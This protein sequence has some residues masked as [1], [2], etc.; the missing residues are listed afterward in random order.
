MTA[1]AV[2][3]AVVVEHPPIYWETILQ[4]W[5]RKEGR[6]YGAIEP[7]KWTKPSVELTPETS[8]GFDVIEF[9]ETVCGI[10]LYPWQRWL[11]IHALELNPDGTY[12]FKRVHLLVG[13]QNGK[14]TLA[15]LLILYWLF[16]DASA[17]PDKLHPRD[18]SILA[19]AQN[20]EKAAETWEEVLDYCD[21]APP[22]DKDAATMPLVPALQKLSR[23][24]SRKT[25]APLVRTRVGSNYGIASIAGTKSG[26]G[27]SKARIFLDE[28]REHRSWDAWNAIKNTKNARWNAQLWT[29]SNAGDRRAVVLKELRAQ[30]LE[31]IDEYEKYV[32][33][34]LWD[35]ERWANKHDATTGLFEWSAEPGIPQSDVAGILQSNPSVG[36][37]NVDLDTLVADSKSDPEAEFRTEVLCQWVESLVTPHIDPT[38]WDACHSKTAYPTG[39]LVAGF[40]VSF[41]RKRAHVAIAGIGAD[42]IPVVELATRRTGSAWILNYAEKLRENWGVNEIAI[43]SRGC[44][45]SEWV[46]PLRAAGFHVHEIQGF[47]VGASCGLFKE[48]VESTGVRHRDQN[49]LTLSVSGTQAK[50]NG[51]QMF[52]DRA[53]SIVD[54]SATVAVSEAV[55][56]LLRL[57]EPPPPAESVYESRGIRVLRG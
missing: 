10:I 1:V 22:K 2:A 9:G 57:E 45:A 47:H 46:D 51:E 33:T 24:P 13:R 20:L 7:R 32:E 49:A 17:N 3:P 40:D 19:S 36:W 39:R 14:T 5:S 38:W 41:D 55:Y 16:I 53:S 35:L 30:A 29:A 4:G 56:A 31:A 18:F 50:K 48:L 26:R 44:G 37:G 28:L 34:G 23:K 25:G 21:P 8:A 27:G 15:K 6:E 12:R 43:Q 54:A 11:L 42:G 52:W